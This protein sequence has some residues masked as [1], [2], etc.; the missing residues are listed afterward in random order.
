VEPL[1][2]GQAFYLFNCGGE[3]IE[4]TPQI[5]GVHAVSIVATS[6][7]EDHTKE[8]FKAGASMLYMPMWDL[9]ELEQ[10][11]LMCVV[12]LSANVVAERFRVWGGVARPAF[13]SGDAETLE[14]RMTSSLVKFREKPQDVLGLV[15]SHDTLQVSHTLVHYEVAAG[16][17]TKSVILASDY[18][19][20]RMCAMSLQGVVDRIRVLQE[21]DDQAL[22][23]KLFERFAHRVLPLGDTPEHRLLMQPAGGGHRVAIP[24]PSSAKPVPIASMSDIARQ[25]NGAYLLPTARN[26]PVVDAL[27]KPCTGYQMTVSDSHGIAE[28]RL[29]D[30]VRV[31]GCKKSNPFRLVWVVPADVEFICPALPIALNQFVLQYILKLR[32]TVPPT[33][34][35]RES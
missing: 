5:K 28:D 33:L 27:V 8:F 30:L 29:E 13:F 23:G 16:F 14:L 32:L 11:R 12:P 20:D 18:I 9:D 19:G 7:C 34:L 35:R 31:L 2:D 17:R 26:F 21:M 3:P 4:L 1:R 10:C 24:K 15:G 6:P 22:R 25:P